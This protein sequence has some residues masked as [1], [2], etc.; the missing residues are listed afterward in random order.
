[1]KNNFQTPKGMHDILPLDQI[2]YQRIINTASKVFGFWGCEKIDTPILE[3]AELFTKSVGE[4]TDIVEKEMYSLKTKGKDFLVLRPEGTAPVVRS[5]IQH[6]MHT[7]PQPVKLWYAG[8]FF[9]YEKPQAG[10]FRQFWQFGTEIIGEEDSVVDAQTILMFYKTLKDLGLKDLIVRINS[11]GDDECRPDYKKLLLKYLKNKKNSLCPDCQRRLKTNPLRVLDCKQEKCQE[12]LAQAPQMVDSLCP[13]CH[14]HFKEVLEFLDELKISYY[15]DP[16]LVRGL[17]YYT[18]TVFEI[19]LA[20]SQ[21]DLT[22]AGG[23]RYDMLV[24]ML[25]GGDIP[26]CGGAAGIERIIEILKS[27][28]TRISFP[29]PAQVFLAQIGTLAKKKSLVLLEEFR[30]AN[31]K[32]EETLGKDSLKTQLNR[33]DKIG[34]KIALII[35]QKESLGETVIIRDMKTGRQTTV[36]Q[37]NIVKEVKKRLKK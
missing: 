13:Q 9:R 35:G 16:F 17:D 11:I 20:T 32:V 10:R 6:G 25:G 27:Q 23:G 29:A 24:Q 5:Y 8:Q 22:L 1:M 37:E 12:V 2:Y 33:A 4:S 26:A 7:L 21:E 18:K 31:I 3:D 19:K 15:L 14:K 36:S 34:A 28:K 30:K